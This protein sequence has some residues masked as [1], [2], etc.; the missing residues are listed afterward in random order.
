M[1]EKQKKPVKGPLQRVPTR[2]LVASIRQD[3]RKKLKALEPD[4]LPQK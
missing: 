3:L 1:T 4:K 2:K